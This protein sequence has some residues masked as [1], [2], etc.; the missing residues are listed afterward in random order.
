M[1]VCVLMCV[2]RGVGAD[3]WCV[4]VCAVRGGRGR[5]GVCGCVSHGMGTDVRGVCVRTWRGRA[6]VCVCGVGWGADVWGVGGAARGGR[7][8]VW[9]VCVWRGVDADVHGF[10]PGF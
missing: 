3:V 9:C 7:R 10:R 1:R 6:G 8:R 5:A 2:W 4:N